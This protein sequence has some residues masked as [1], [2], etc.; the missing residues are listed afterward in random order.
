MRLK[1]GFILR[2][3]LVIGT[4][5]GLVLLWSSLSPKPSDEKPFGKRDDSLL[6]KGGPADQFKPVVPWPHVEGVEVDLNSIRLKHGEA[7]HPQNPEQ[8]E[9]NQKQVI[10]QQ[11]V[12]FKPHTHAYTSPILKKGILGNFEPKE[13]EPP[14]VPGGPGEGAQPFVLGPEYKD[15]VQASIK[16]FGFN[17]VA[18]DMISLDRTIS[19]IR[20]EEENSMNVTD[21]YL[22]LCLSPPDVTHLKERLEEY[23]KQWNGLVKVFRNEKRE[24]LIQAR[25][26][27]A[28]KAVKG[29]VLIYLD[30]HC[31]VGINWYAPLIAPISK[32]RTVCTVPL[33]D[34]INGQ[35]FSIDPQGGG[36]Q[37]GFARGAWDWSM[38][39]KRIPLGDR[40]KA[41]RHTQ[42]EPYRSPAM[43]GGLFAIE[44][45]FFFELGLYDP[46]LQIWG[47]ENFEISY[48]IWQCG[49]Q[50]LFVP[51]S[52]VG[53]IYRLQGWQGNPPPAHVGSSPTLKNYVRVVEVW[54]DDYK[55]YFYATRP[56]TLTLAYGDISELKRF[57]EEHRCKSFKW[58]ME[59]IAYDI[60]VHYPLPPKNVEW[61]EIRGFETS[62]C[63]DS[64]GHTNGGT[65]EIGPCHRMGG[66]QDLHRFTH[67]PT[68]KCLDRSDVLHKVFLSDCDTSKTTQKWEMNNIVACLIVGHVQS[69]DD[70]SVLLRDIQVLT[71]YKGRYTTARRSSPVPQL[72][73][74]GG[75]AGCHAFIPDVVQ[76]Q[77]KGWDGVDVQWEC[78]T[79]MDNAYRF[80]RLEVS[81]EGYNH[82]ADPYILRGSCGLEY[83]LELTEEGRRRTQGSWGSHGGFKGFGDLGGFASSFFSGFSGNQ[84][85]HR[86]KSHQSSYPSGGEDSGGLLVV[87]VLLLLAYGVYKLFL[88]GNTAQWGQNGGQAGYPRDN[89]HGFTTGPPPP[90]F[91]PD[92]TDPS[93]ANQGYG[94]RSDYTHGQQYPGGQAAPGTGGG[95]WSGMGTGGVLGYLFGSQR[96]QQH[97]N[98]HY[99]NYNDSRR[100]FASDSSSSSSSSSSGT[101]TA[102]ALCGATGESL[103]AFLAMPC[104]CLVNLAYIFM[105]LSWLLWDGGDGETEIS[106]YMRHVFA[107]MAVFYAPVQWTRLAVLRRAPALLDQWF[108]L[109]I[110]AWVPVWIDFI[111]RGPAKWSVAHAAVIELCSLFSY[112][113][114]LVHERGFEAALGCHVGVAVYKGVRLQLARGDARTRRYLLLAMLSCAGFVVLKLLD[115]WL[116][117]YWLFQRFTGHF[118]SKVCDVL[119]FHFSFWFLTSLM[120]NDS[121]EDRLRWWLPSGPQ[122]GQACLP[123]VLVG[124][125]DKR[126]NTTVQ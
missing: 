69:W 88:S 83:S 11:Y 13:P 67:V 121:S 112:G 105:G 17:M 40:E 104:N 63:I 77:N 14:G 59:E 111:E 61:G 75:S 21:L 55:D 94:F 29:Q 108:T 97:H 12:T 27:G 56:E 89:N 36:D 31:E 72:Q 4:F 119:Q 91:K 8:R 85:Q 42:T 66:N 30:A 33:I 125:V 39:W 122:Q 68:G 107:L 110:F 115:H 24:G 57:R 6:P 99:P 87:A 7:D 113:L 93:G 3:L 98:Y 126:V 49:G 54:W 124:A 47:G 103:P 76:C 79:D 1:V 116:A 38:L 51:C 10:Q 118:W 34:S 64:M 52:R 123:E 45:D 28:R 74:V 44:R 22:L 65:V 58:F 82:P 25:S 32:D 26:I 102:S 20:H 95:F 37:D 117:R 71:L 60:P 120:F 86:Q 100:P 43:A 15:S 50:L 35:Q 19:D 92:Y 90:G 80:G 114:A 23:I 16:E 5:L 70:G 109:P 9:P 73:C 53:H 84:H 46:G 78:K 101:R 18:S 62:Y 41:L 106:R 96:R 81:C 48:K 2:S